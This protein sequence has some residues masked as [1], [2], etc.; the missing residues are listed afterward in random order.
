MHKIG[1]SLVVCALALSLISPIHSNAQNPQA[2]AVFVMTNAA[3]K[4]EILSF[5]RAADG[6]LQAPRR[7]AT[8]GRGSGGNTDPLGSQGSLTLSQDR[9]F[10]FAVGISRARRHPC[11][12]ATDSDRRQ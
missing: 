1:Y 4:N 8:G 5:Q 12:D 9:S 10:L 11:P 7:F 2:G 6:T 3:D